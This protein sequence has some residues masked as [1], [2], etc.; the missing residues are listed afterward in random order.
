MQ[1]PTST[2]P[3]I[4][5]PPKQVQDHLIQIHLQHVH[6]LLPFANG[7]QLLA[8]VSGENP[9]QMTNQMP[10]SRILIL[11]LCAYSACLS[12]TLGGLAPD[13]DSLDQER[14]AG[15]SLAELWAEEARSTL[16]A[17][18]LRRRC[19]VDTIQTIIL[20]V[21]RDH[22]KAQHFQAWLWLGG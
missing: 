1:G 21:L 17:S 13:I 16:M 15:G 14:S 4:Q 3:Q 5:V 9:A 22:G 11:A 8:Y 19:G 18:T 2:I 6:P 20:L 12:P 7:E 10:P